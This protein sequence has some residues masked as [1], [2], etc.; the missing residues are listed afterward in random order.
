MDANKRLTESLEADIASQ[1]YAELSRLYK[2][3]PLKTIDFGE[4]IQNF[5]FVHH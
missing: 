2:D 4:I 3:A 5:G 1:I